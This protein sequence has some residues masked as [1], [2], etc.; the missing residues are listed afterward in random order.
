M[1]SSSDASRSYLMA[2]R[3]LVLALLVF[4]VT[5]IVGVLAGAEMLTAVLVATSLWSVV[6]AGGVYCG[7]RGDELSR[8]AL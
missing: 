1:V 4:H 2:G 3:L 7:W 8:E 6:M 5:W